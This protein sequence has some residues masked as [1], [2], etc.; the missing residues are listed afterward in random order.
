MQFA[1][2]HDYAGFSKWELKEREE[3][4]YPPFCRI[5]QIKMQA[6]NKEKLETAANTLA[7]IFHSPLSTLHSKISI[8][9]P[10]EP[11][12]SKAQK[13]HRMIITIKATSSA[14]LKNV[15]KNALANQDFAKKAK[16]VEIRI[17]RDS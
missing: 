2:K 17:D 5:A 6:K 3:A 8:L 13:Y 1:I 10:T 15:I 9:G 4:F 14:D 12:I 16:G 7:Q 11:I